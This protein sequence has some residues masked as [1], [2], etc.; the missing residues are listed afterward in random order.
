MEIICE[1]WTKGTGVVESKD[2]YAR[3]QEEGITPA[4][5]DMDAFLQLLESQGSIRAAKMH[6]RDEIAKH[7][8]M[9]I[10]DVSDAMCQ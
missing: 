1:E 6:G 3:L 4:E 9:A 2:V 7:G 5:G 10:T 8:N